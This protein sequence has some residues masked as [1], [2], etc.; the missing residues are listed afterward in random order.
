MSEI[1]YH[2]CPNLSS[3]KKFLPES[4][5]WPWD[6]PTWRA[7]AVDHWQRKH[8]GYN[9]NEL[10]VNQVREYFGEV[11]EALPQFIR[12]SQRGICK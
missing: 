3:L 4:D 7:H 1:G 11:P 2:G 12:A 6:N 10:M 5:L 8:R 9:R